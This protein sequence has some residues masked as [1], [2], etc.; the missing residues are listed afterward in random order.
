MRRLIDANDRKVNVYLRGTEQPYSLYEAIACYQSTALCDHFK[1][2]DGIP[3]LADEAIDE[4]TMREVL[5]WM[6][7]NQLAFPHCILNGRV[8]NNIEKCAMHW[9]KIWVAADKLEMSQLKD[10]ALKLMDY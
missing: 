10:V 3:Y 2:G 6:D 5:V 8:D 1:N 4:E 7:G 9:V